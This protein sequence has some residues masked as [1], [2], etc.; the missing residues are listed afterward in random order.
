MARRLGGMGLV[1]LLASSAVRAAEPPPPEPLPFPTPV[2]A[3]PVPLPTMPYQVREDPYARWYFLGVDRQGFFRP[4]VIY[5][6]YGSYYLYNG[7]PF[8][9]AIM[10]QRE[11]M[12]Y[13]TD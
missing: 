9:W 7:K 11:W 1:V 8:P 3:D 13:L 10:H 6:P 2:H 12:P 5:S 4:R